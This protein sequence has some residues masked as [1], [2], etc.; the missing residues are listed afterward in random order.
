MA[1]EKMDSFESAFTVELELP[2][3]KEDD[4][5]IESS[6]EES[7]V[8]EPEVSDEESPEGQ[9]TEPSLPESSDE[10]DE[11]SD[12]W[13]GKEEDKEEPKKVSAKDLAKVFS[14]YIPGLEVGEDVT[15][16]DLRKSLEEVPKK[17][18]IEYVN[19]LPELVRDFIY[20]QAA[21]ENPTEESLRSFFDAYLKPQFDIESFN[22]EEE[23]GAERFLRHTEEFTSL[24]DTDEEISD[25]I[26]YLKDKGTLVDKAKKIKERKLKELEEQRKAAVEEQKRIEAEREKQREI[27]QKKLNEELQSLGWA[28][29]R[30][31]R[32]LSEI[33]Q[34][35]KIQD[36][37]N[38][39]T[40][41]P[42]ALIQFGDILSYFDEQKGFDELY[43]ILEGKEN[44]KKVK[45]MK[46][47]IEEDSL[48]TLLRNTSTSTSNEDSLLYR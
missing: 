4:A 8:E 37:L 19:S 40:R 25:A 34:G 26:A 24:Y 46:R 41:S 31:R 35:N 3:K 29:G 23:S 12:I 14:E 36:K 27:F 47:S 22:V 13:G 30:K 28:D 32:A 10:D 11:L 15:E 48:G 45:T 33:T 1:E 2:V 44:S 43:K 39:I 5:P 38:A 9:T 7:N 21:Q 16:E 20:F 42:K 17:M 18:L 6:E